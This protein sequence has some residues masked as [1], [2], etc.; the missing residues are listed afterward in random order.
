MDFVCKEIQAQLSFD[1][2]LIEFISFHSADFF[3]GMRTTVQVF[4]SSGDVIQV[5]GTL[6][7]HSE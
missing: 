7:G 1:Y 5:W 2:S 3:T 6:L 4:F